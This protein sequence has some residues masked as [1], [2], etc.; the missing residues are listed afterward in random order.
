TKAIELCLLRGY[1]HFEHEAP[2]A[3]VQ[4]LRQPLQ[5]CGLTPVH[6]KVAFGIVPDQYLAEGRV[7]RLDMLG[8]VLAIFKIELVLTAFFNRTR[9]RVT[10]AERVA[11]NGRAE[12]LVHQNP[13]LVFG[14][15]GRQG[16]LEGV[17]DHFLGGSN[18][19][20]L[21]RGQFALPSE[22]VLLKSGA[23]I[24]RQNV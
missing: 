4:I 12:L 9:R 16:A 8:E 21:L 24:K 17:I 10:V 19:R 7:K 6:I 11:Q 15:A 3:A 22:E 23:M 2:A 5:S 1:E 18:L 14:H 20:R 13:G